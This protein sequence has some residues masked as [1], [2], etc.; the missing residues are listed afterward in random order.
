M[1]PGR[2]SRFGKASCSG[3]FSK[4]RIIR[5]M[6]MMKNTV[7][8]MIVTVIACAFLCTGCTSRKVIEVETTVPELE[9]TAH[10]ETNRTESVEIGFEFED[11]T[12]LLTEA[13]EI[14]QNEECV[15][16]NSESVTE[17]EENQ[18]SSEQETGATNNGSNAGQNEQDEET[19]AGDNAEYRYQ[20]DSNSLGDDEF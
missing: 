15:T 1:P 12:E 8:V 13:T 10:E 14:N 7:F 18:S 17:A 19:S 3:G 4:F 9:V 6:I 5:G 2:I 11:E 20:K 16:S